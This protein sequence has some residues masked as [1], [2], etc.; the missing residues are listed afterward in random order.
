MGLQTNNSELS[1][2]VRGKFRLS[3][4]F[5]AFIIGSI[6]ASSGTWLAG[7]KNQPSVEFQ[8]SPQVSNCQKGKSK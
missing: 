5:L 3:P 7:T 8:S 6:I 2:D 4:T 1:L